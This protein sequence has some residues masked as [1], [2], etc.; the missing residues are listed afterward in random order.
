M[1]V[2]LEQGLKFDSNDLG[3]HHYRRVTSIRIPHISSKVLLTASTERNVWLEAAEIIFDA[4][5]DIYSAPKGHRLATRAQTTFVEE[6]DRL[7]DRA[8]RIFDPLRHRSR[9]NSSGV[10][11]YWHD[12]YPSERVIQTEP[13]TKMTFIFPNP[14]FLLLWIKSFQFIRN[15]N[16]ER[17][18]HGEYLGK[19]IRLIQK[20]RQENRKLIVMQ[21]SRK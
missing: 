18:L 21:D 19:Q 3:A 11:T 15:D 8:K 6:Q 20:T 10:W 9:L 13:S 17:D 2:C 12:A 16:P 7:T 5:L 14:L 4:Y 1:V